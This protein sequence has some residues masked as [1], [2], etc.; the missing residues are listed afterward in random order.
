M[1]KY[2]QVKD[3]ENLMKRFLKDYIIMVIL[4]NQQERKIPEPEVYQL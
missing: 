4:Y 1:I 2:K 3:Q